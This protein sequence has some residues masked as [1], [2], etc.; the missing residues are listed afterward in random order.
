MFYYSDSFGA[1][2]GL[3]S[4]TCHFGPPVNLH[5]RNTTFETKKISDLAG[6]RALN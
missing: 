3:D 2:E 6:T 4:D 5:W 1:G